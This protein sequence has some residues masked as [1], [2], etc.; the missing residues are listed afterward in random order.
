MTSID[1]ILK[2]IEAGA[3]VRI[4]REPFDNK[5]RETVEVVSRWLPFNRR[6]QLT[7]EELVRVRAALTQRLPDGERS[8]VVRI[9]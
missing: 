8:G 6:Y 4:V 7:R 2:K 3:T 9:K 1:R 5:R